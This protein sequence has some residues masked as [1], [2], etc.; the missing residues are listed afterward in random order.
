MSGLVKLS[1]QLFTCDRLQPP[2]VARKQPF[3]FP[4]HLL[5]LTTPVTMAMETFFNH[6]GV[7]CLQNGSAAQQSTTPRAPHIPNPRRETR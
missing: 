6:L 1:H 2:R 3:A 5:D 4:F 7:L